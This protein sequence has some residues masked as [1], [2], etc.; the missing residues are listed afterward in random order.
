M[1][2]ACDECLYGKNA[3]ADKD[4]VI[5]RLNGKY[6]ICHKATIQDPNWS[7]MCR[8]YYEQ[9]KDS[10]TLIRLGK[11]LERIKFITAL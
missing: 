9:N 4:E 2:K 5:D 8:G 1:E 11:L 10:S 3:I 6:F 7:V